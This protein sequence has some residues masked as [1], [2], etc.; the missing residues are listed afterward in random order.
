MHDIKYPP[1]LKGIANAN[2]IFDNTEIKSTS[3]YVFTLG[4]AAVS[5]KSTKQTCISRST[6]EF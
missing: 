2:W 6:I 3:V 4:G 5:W 1:I